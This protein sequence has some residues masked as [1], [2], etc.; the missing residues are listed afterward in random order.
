MPQNKRRVLIVDD[1]VEIRLLIRTGLDWVGVYEVLEAKTGEQALEIAG[2][3]PLD[4]VLMDVS[5]PGMGGLE[6]CRRLKAKQGTQIA[7]VVFLS[8]WVDD[9]D[10]ASVLDAGG[11]EFIS[12]PFNIRCL[13]QTVA[14]YT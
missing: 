4:L 3:Y 9:V 7:P 13:L 14:R 6:A 8:A 11:A 2:Q 10:R 5:M 12:K 1:E